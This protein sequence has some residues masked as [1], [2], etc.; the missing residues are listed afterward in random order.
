VPNSCSLFVATDSGRLTFSPACQIVA[1]YS[2]QRH[3]QQHSF[4]IDKKMSLF[5]LLSVPNPFK[6]LKTLYHF[7]KLA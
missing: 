4:L 3:P 6:S 5:E 1:P 2:S 7:N